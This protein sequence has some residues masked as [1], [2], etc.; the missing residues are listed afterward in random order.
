MSR[1]KSKRESALF[2]VFDQIVTKFLEVFVTGVFRS[3][4]RWFDSF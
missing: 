1:K 2:T 3:I 4:G